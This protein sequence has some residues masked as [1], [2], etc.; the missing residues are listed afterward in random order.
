MKLTHNDG[1]YGPFHRIKTRKQDYTV[2]KMQIE[3]QEIWGRAIVIGGK[4]AKAKAYLLPLCFGQ[5]VAV[6]CAD[7]EGVE[8]TT[9]VKPDVVTPGGTVYWEF[10]PERPGVRKV[11]DEFVALEAKVYK[12][13]Y[14]EER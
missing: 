4:F 13:N 6:A 3:S 5:T 11:D 1:V 7:E 8:F 10:K 12:L 2:A 9:H 14:S